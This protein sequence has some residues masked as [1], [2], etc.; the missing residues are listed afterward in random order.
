[1]K[2]VASFAGGALADRVDRGRLVA[3]GWL[4]YAGSYLA[5]GLATQAWQAVAIFLAY[6]T[7]HGLTEPAEK[8]L[9]KGLAPAGARA[10]DTASI[11]W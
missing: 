9:V 3:A 7:F 6:G 2:L 1:V 8:A 5:F 11:T 4:V 10:S